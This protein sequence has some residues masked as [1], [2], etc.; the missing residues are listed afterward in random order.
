MKKTILLVDDEADLRE[1]LDI[2]LSDTGYNV[3][4]AENSTQAL[5]LLNDN[6][7]PVVITDIKMPGIDGIELLRK[8][9][10]KN[11][12]TEVIM[13]TGHGDLELA[14][15]SLKHE[16][17]DF[18]TKPIN[19]DA[20]EMALVRAFEK[21]STRQKLKEYDRN[22]AMYDVLINELIQE[23]V[24]IIGSDYRVLDINETLLA[25][26]GLERKEAVGRYC[27]EIT[28]RLTKP[29]SGEDHKCPL[30][31][32]LMTRKPTKETHIHKDKDNKNIHYSISAYPLFENGEIIGAI[33]L[34]RDITA[35]INT[36]QAMMQQDK[37]ASIGRLSA[38][39]AHEIN[40][41]LTTI[42]TTAMLIQEDIDP[43]NPMY[44]ELGTITNETLRCRKIVASLLD[45][46]RQTKPTKK[47]HNINDIII[48][49]IGLTRKQAEFK[50]VQ[51][52]KALSEQVPELLLDKEQIQQALINLILNAT[53]ATDP[54]GKITV[55]TALSPDNQFVNINVSD[56]GKGIAAEVV[57]KIFEP[58]FTTR[59]IGTG[60]GLAITHGIIGRHGGDIRVQSR[61]GQGTTF[62]IRLPHNQGN[63]DDHP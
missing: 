39:V 44:E 45:F 4:T 41:P 37:L 38:G 42:L 24:L 17:T 19:D 36:R 54:G 46:A 58:F 51:I 23:D 9:K 5:D 62:T 48:E 25:T 63:Q 2:S 18:I 50:D 1:V 15:K 47:Y 10:S 7:I 49:C 6:D 57:D 43:D 14:I 3:L 56:T 27:Y 60:L 8:I 52:L 30:K 21:I 55:S 40:N 59:E 61:P 28:H 16:A 11:P 32:T 29:C 26:L 13:L 53:D 35:D 22:R 12:E 34:S 31:E 20:L 33:E